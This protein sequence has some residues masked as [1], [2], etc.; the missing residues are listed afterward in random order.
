MK[1]A[2]SEGAQLGRA[3]VV[4]AIL[5]LVGNWWHDSG[6]LAR[7]LLI[8]V[9]LPVCFGVFTIYAVRQAKKAKT[10]GTLPRRSGRS[11]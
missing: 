1:P 2:G 8:A 10:Q 3:L 9:G 5:V 7:V 11:R 6:L 4:L